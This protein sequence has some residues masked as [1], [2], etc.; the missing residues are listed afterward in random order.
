MKK[1]DKT[2]LYLMVTSSYNTME[3]NVECI[4]VR[5]STS[6]HLNQSV[7]VRSLQCSCSCWVTAET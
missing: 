6:D 3:N 7:K 4:C 5:L 2:V 1:Q